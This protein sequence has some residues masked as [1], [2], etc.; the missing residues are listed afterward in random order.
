MSCSSSLLSHDDGAVLQS[1]AR[2]LRRI[3][4]RLLLEHEAEPA[5]GL[6]EC[7]KDK[8]ALDFINQA[9]SVRFVPT[10]RLEIVIVGLLLWPA[11][12]HE[13][14]LAVGFYCPDLA[15]R[16]DVAV[17]LAHG[18][19][20]GFRRPDGTDCLGAE[21]EVNGLVREGNSLSI[22]VQEGEVGDAGAALPGFGEHALRDIECNVGRGVR[23]DG[24]SIVPSAVADLKGSL[25]RERHGLQHAT[26][27]EAF[28]IKGG[29]K[30]R[31]D[32]DVG[33]LGLVPVFHR[34]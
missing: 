10:K 20:L 23:R 25:V 29:G 1:W 32:V 24:L 27:D 21:D 12:I 13:V 5:L 3:A 6:G 2:V 4:V 22:G 15:T 28:G 18:A 19:F 34:Q 7:G 14:A 16:L 26:P 17:N 11:Q 33:G 30:G 9:E 8:G 31:I